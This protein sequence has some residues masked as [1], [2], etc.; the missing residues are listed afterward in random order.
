MENRVKAPSLPI[1]MTRIMINLLIGIRS[2]VIPVESPTV[3]KADTTSNKIC[4][5]SRSGSR[6]HSRNVAIQ[7][8]RIDR[9]EI[10]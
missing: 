10:T 4:I 7:T 5:N 6:I 8:T 3:P 9:K 2:G 1:N